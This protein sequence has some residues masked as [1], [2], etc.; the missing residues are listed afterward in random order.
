MVKHAIF[1]IRYHV[2]PTD[3]FDFSSK[4]A[5]SLLIVLILRPLF[6]NVF[7]PKCVEAELF[8]FKLLKHAYKNSFPC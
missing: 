2:V 7:S 8:P 4:N 6:R 5:T 3:R 1:I